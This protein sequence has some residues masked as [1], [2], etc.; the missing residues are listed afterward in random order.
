MAGKG[1]D[2]AIVTSML[3]NGK[4][5]EAWEELDALLA[6]LNDWPGTHFGMG[7]PL[8]ELP[9][10]GMLG[11]LTDYI[12]HGPAENFQPMNSNLGL[13]PPIEPKIKKKDERHAALIAR[14]VERMREVA[15]AVG[16]GDGIE[17][18]EAV[19]A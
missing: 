16:R 18:P 6:N 19:V 2:A 4:D 1:L 15:I 7:K 9:V 8:V 17:V 10:E 14:G 5:E 3:H 12:A 11:A 13:L